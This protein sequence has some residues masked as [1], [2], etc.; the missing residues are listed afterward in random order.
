MIRGAPRGVITAALVLLAGLCLATLLMP[1]FLTQVRDELLW[2]EHSATPTLA[3]LNA[4]LR[5]CSACFYRRQ[6]TAALAEA[7]RSAGLLAWLDTVYLYGRST[8]EVDR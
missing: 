6:V 8:T 7:G 5:E 1:Q 3:S 4:Y 2:R